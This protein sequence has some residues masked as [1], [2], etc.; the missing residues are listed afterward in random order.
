MVKDLNK[1]F[2]DLFT[3]FVLLVIHQ[4]VVPRN[5]FLLPLVPVWIGSFFVDVL[6]LLFLPA[7]SLFTIQVFLLVGLLPTLPNQLL[8]WVMLFLYFPH[9]NQRTLLRLLYLIVFHVGTLTA[10]PLFLS[11]PPPPYPQTPRQT[12]FFR[13][14]RTSALASLNRPHQ[15]TLFVDRTAVAFFPRFD[16][17][18]YGVPFTAIF[19][20]VFIIDAGDFIPFAVAFLLNCAVKFVRLRALFLRFYHFSDLLHP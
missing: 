14:I 7:T 16:D 8:K 18:S 15:L 19:F 5:H 10:S 6:D 20:L 2:V 3:I 4:R 11:N 9:L 1:Y 13:F 17:Y 12:I